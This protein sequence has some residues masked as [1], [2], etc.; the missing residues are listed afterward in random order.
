MYIAVLPDPVFPMEVKTRR[1]PSLNKLMFLLGGHWHHGSALQYRKELK[2]D[3]VFVQTEFQEH[4]EEYHGF[5]GHVNG[6]LW[7]LQGN[8]AEILH[9][10][11]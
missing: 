3:Y 11:H 5:L 7:L 9:K 10:A 4:R 8:Y 2:G 1:S 6:F